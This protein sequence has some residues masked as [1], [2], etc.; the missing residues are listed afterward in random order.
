MDTTGGGEEAAADAPAPE[1][2]GTAGGDPGQLVLS[3]SASLQMT[4]S[5]KV[6]AAPR[7]LRLAQLQLPL[8]DH[9][10]ED[11]RSEPDP[12]TPTPAA[13]VTPGQFSQAMS[14]IER[15][16]AVRTV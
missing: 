5:G 1:T 4:D 14:T 10:H 7:L 6:K 9:E 3:K 2:G 8:G 15:R 12:A 16:T 11:G 13:H